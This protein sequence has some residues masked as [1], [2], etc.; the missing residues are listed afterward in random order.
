MKGNNWPPVL[1]IQ[2]IAKIVRIKILKIIQYIEKKI[3]INPQLTN[4]RVQQALRINTMNSVHDCMYWR[5]FFS[6]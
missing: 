6:E 3:V 1:N 2:H 4:I 5:V